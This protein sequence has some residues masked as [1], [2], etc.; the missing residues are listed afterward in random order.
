[1]V[2]GTDQATFTT[3]SLALGPHT[4]TASYR[5]DSNFGGNTN[6]STLTQNVDTNLSGY[7]KLPNGAYN[8]SN[9]NLA[10]GYFAGLNLTNA[11]L[12]GSNLTNAVFTN[13]NL[14]GANLSNSNFITGATFTNANLTNANLSN[15]NL[16]GASFSG[17]TLSGANLTNSNLTGA[18]GL[19]T[20][21]G[22]TSVI[23]NKTACPDGTLSNSDG[24]TCVGHL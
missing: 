15:S 22:I 19:A 7:P 10:G 8:L 11:S 5:G 16:K 9:T 21:T 17:V 24:G 2:G 12:T 14:T 13:A 18:T 20:A 23:W 3:S 4:I 1:V 6:P